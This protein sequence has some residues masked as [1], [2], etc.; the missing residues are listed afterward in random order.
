MRQRQMLE[1]ACLRA[2]RDLKTFLDAHERTPKDSAYGD[3]E[4]MLKNSLL[5]ADR[6]L[7]AHKQSCDFCQAESRTPPA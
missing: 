2:T 7:D 5:N 6:A 3:Q 1:A 4:E